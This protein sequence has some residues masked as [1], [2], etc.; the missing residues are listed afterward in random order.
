MLLAQL[1]L[2]AANCRVWSAAYPL[3]LMV[4]SLLQIHM[5]WIVAIV[6]HH[7]LLQLVLI[8]LLG[9][10]WTEHLSVDRRESC[11]IIDIIVAVLVAL[12]A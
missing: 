9:A 2:S 11:A 3:L 5:T 8:V 12:V 10:A 4:L 7:L 6:G 1:L